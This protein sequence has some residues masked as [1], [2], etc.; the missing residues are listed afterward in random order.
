M[1]VIIV[2]I[3]GMRLV[4]EGVKLAPC[5]HLATCLR[6]MRA[7]RL[8]LIVCGARGPGFQELFFAKD[9]GVDVVG[10]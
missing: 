1:N 9:Q 10:G 7:L 2:V 5:F 3:S 6:R 4:S 8:L